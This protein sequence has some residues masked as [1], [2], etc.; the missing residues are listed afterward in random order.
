M[1]TQTPDTILTDLIPTEDD[2]GDVSLTSRELV[3]L[4]KRTAE[5]AYEAAEARRQTFA[6][7]PDGRRDKTIHGYKPLPYHT[8]LGQSTPLLLIEGTGTEEWHGDTPFE[9]P[10]EVAATF[11]SNFPSP[12]LLSERT[13]NA[14][15]SQ[16]ESTPPQ[17]ADEEATSYRGHDDDP[18]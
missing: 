4:L 13:V 18:S 10:S 7:T 17:E 11:F 15:A 2:G 1:E 16:W 3:Q 14:E 9:L 5:I 12:L 8:V 6:T